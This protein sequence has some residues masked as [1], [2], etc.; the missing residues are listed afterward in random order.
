MKVD[1]VM[2]K[3]REARE[4]RPGGRFVFWGAGQRWGDRIPWSPAGVTS[5]SS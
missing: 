4:A 1:D 3:D 2:M 5:G